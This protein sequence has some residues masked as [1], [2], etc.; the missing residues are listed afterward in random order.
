[1]VLVQHD[2]GIVFTSQAPMISNFTTNDDP[3]NA[4]ET[5][6]VSFEVNEA[7][8]HSPVVRM[9][10]ESL[11][12]TSADGASP[13]VFELD[14]S[15]GDFS[16]SG[17]YLIAIELE[18]VIGNFVIIEPST[19]LVDTIPPGLSQL[20]FTPA[21]VRVGLNAVLTVSANEPLFGAAD[22]SLANAPILIWDEQ[23]SLPGLEAMART[24]FGWDFQATIDERVA[25]GS[26]TIASI[27]LKDLA[28]NV[29]I[30]N[31]GLW[32]TSTIE[33]D[34]TPPEVT[35][36]SLNGNRFSAQVGY[37]EVVVDFDLLDGDPPNVLLGTRS[38]TCGAAQTE[39]PHYTCT[40]TLDGSETEGVNLIQIQASDDAGNYG[41]A[42]K[43]L[44]LDKT[45]R[46]VV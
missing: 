15:S 34:T 20:A 12:Q 7:L 39:S 27:E 24:E 4:T 13:Y 38:M 31:T 8:A 17:A 32:P 41:Y 23:A 28:E 25:S 2:V 10:Q 30:V 26:Y 9:G 46:R 45:R 44:F 1:M 35:N 16:L 19:V 18:D 33:V 42:S 3:F 43:S 22:E 11:T 29:T 36:L 40:L 6:E 5:L 37:N 14:F 21:L